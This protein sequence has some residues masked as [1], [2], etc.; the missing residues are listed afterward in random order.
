MSWTAEKQR[1]VSWTATAAFHGLRELS[2]WH[3][4]DCRSVEDGYFVVGGQFWAKCG[5]QVQTPDPR[6]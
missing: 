1:V 3:S 4:M 2:R 5:P 6:P